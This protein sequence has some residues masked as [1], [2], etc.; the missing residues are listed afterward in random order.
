MSTNCQ[1]GIKTLQPW[2]RKYIRDGRQFNPSFV[3]CYKSRG[4]VLNVWGSSMQ[5]EDEEKYVYEGDGVEILHHSR[6][7]TILGDTDRFTHYKVVD[8]DKVLYEVDG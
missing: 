4:E 5:Q 2:F 6:V 7:T 8:K 3:K 1:E